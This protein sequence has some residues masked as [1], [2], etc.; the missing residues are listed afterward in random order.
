MAIASLVRGA[1]GTLQ[2]PALT[3]EDIEQSRPHEGKVENAPLVTG[4]ILSL[5]RDAKDLVSDH[6]LDCILRT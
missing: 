5:L 2:A 6:E 4:D 1:D 3:E